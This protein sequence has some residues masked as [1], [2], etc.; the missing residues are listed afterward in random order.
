MEAE[1]IESEP[2]FIYYINFVNILNNYTINIYKVI[3]S[4]QKS[5]ISIT[6]EF[7]FTKEVS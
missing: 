1:I 3:V 4:Y 2:H 7:L 6:V 5:N